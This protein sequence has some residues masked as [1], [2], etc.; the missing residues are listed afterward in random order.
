MLLSLAHLDTGG[1]AR[2]VRSLSSQLD[3]SRYDVRIFCQQGSRWP[4]R[5]Y[6]ERDDIKSLPVQWGD[7][8]VYRR[9]RLGLVVFRLLAAAR[10]QDVI[11]A[12][13][14]GANSFAC[15]I[16]GKVLRKPV[17]GVVNFAWD[18]LL[19]TTSRRLA[20]AVRRGHGG[21]HA[22]VAASSTAA[23][24]AASS[25]DLP[26]DR[27]NVIPYPHDLAEIDRLAQAPLDASDARLFE[28]P[29]ALCV[30]RLE[31][32]KNHLRLV[33]AFAQA[34]RGG[35]WTLALVGAGSRFD[36]VSARVER[37]GLTGKVRFL[38]GRDNPYALV[39]RSSMLVLSSDFEG[40]PLVIE[41]AL[42][43]GRPVIS[44]DCP[45]GPRESLQGG[46]FGYL[47]DFARHEDLATALRQ[48][49]DDPA[50]LQDLTLRAAAGREHVRGQNAG[51][52]LRW[53]SLINA[54]VEE[55]VLSSS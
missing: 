34:N 48:A 21:F 4:G 51:R 41:E 33:D 8:G 50:F 5:P 37:L 25:L 17:I 31:P 14:E 24:Q 27:V 19:S 28:R 47:A 6:T 11:I 1:I 23:A 7:R 39:S 53:Q 2:L 52:I 55:R 40:Y 13:E 38:G 32:Q 18:V 10:R 35:S 12:C 54:A 16:A 46:R 36:E 29:V 20:W 43:L 42:A 45:T 49:F 22:L 3:S 26:L 44:V 30:A 15:R 9:W